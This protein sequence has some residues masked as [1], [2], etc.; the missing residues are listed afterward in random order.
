MAGEGGGKWRSRVDGEAGG[1]AVAAAAED[2]ACSNGTFGW[3]S[4]RSPP[5]EEPSKSPEK[6]GESGG[7]GNI[8]TN[9]GEEK[10]SSSKSE[11]TR[12][13]A[14][15]LHEDIREAKGFLKSVIMKGELG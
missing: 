10:P 9:V 1:A 13:R 6:P 3:E 15:P 5:G 4:L 14:W 8:N 11:N 12:W 2:A 7:V